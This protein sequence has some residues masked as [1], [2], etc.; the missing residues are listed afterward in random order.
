MQA[1]LPG[2]EELTLHPFG[3]VC[4]QYANDCRPW[5]L[6]SREAFATHAHVDGK[7]AVAPATPLQETEQ[8]P[9]KLAL[10]DKV[11]KAKGTGPKNLVGHSGRG[12]GNQ[13]LGVEAP[14]T[15][16]RTELRSELACSSEH[17]LNRKPRAEHRAQPQ[18]ASFRAGNP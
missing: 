2:R 13:R 1:H 12:G 15:E 7:K 4:A 17:V 8:D 10:L 6:Y 5:T 18:Q 9:A 16:F 14:S 11:K 3:V